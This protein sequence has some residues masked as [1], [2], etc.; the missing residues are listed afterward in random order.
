MLAF[1]FPGQGSQ[2]VGMGK[3]MADRYPIARQT[4]EQ[5]DAALGYSISKLCFEGPIEELT[6]TANSQPAILTTSIA[7]MRVLLDETSLRP[8]M[9][10]GHSLGEYS[11]LVCAEALRFEDAVKLV[12]LRGRFMQE[13]VPEGEGAMAA[14]V[15][16]SAEE[17]AEIQ[18]HPRTARKILE[19]ILE[20]EIAL[21]VVTWHHERWD[22]DGYPNG[23]MGEAIPLS[24]RIV[25]V[26]D[27][28]DAL[29]STRAYRE[30]ME[31]DEAVRKITEERET[32]FDPRVID[33][34]QEALPR[35]EAIYKGN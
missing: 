9:A 30:A 14:I 13:A 16:L 33:A 17:V 2:Q 11:A 20:D 8:E 32:R 22:G 26:A 27:T 34:F 3:A 5:A 19:P 23:L 4:F 29:T 35:L 18:D 1:I 24:A 7:I 6:L 28:L 21:Q 12:H 10:A 15:G 25:A 31:W